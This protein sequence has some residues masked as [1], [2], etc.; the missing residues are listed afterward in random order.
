[1]YLLLMSQNVGNERKTPYGDALAGGLES[2]PVVRLLKRLQSSIAG[3][4]FLDVDQQLNTLAKAASVTV[5]I[6]EEQT[7]PSK[8]GAPSLATM[9]TE[10]TS[11]GTNDES[12]IHQ[13][14]GEGMMLG[15]EE[16]ETNLALTFD[17]AKFSLRSREIM[18]AAAK[19]KTSKAKSRRK[20][21][22][23]IADYADFAFET[24]VPDRQSF[25]S[26]LNS[27]EQRSSG[28]HAKK[29]KIEDIDDPDFGSEQGYEAFDGGDDG[30]MT[31]D[32]EPKPPPQGKKLHGSG[33]ELESSS[34]YSAIESLGRQKKAAKSGAYMVAP[35]YPGLEHE[36]TG[37]FLHRL[38]VVLRGRSNH[39]SRVG[40]R[41]IS[42]V[43]LKNRGLVAHKARINR[44]P[45]VKKRMQYRK[46][47]IRRKGA[48][49]GIRVDEGHKYGGEGTGIKSRISRSR[50]L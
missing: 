7:K 41:A 32:R 17:D 1:M 22:D 36:V 44:N 20:L 49:R 12:N 14:Q 39:V 35:K 27:I 45:R 6:V 48:V 15:S 29:P 2:H 4:S 28:K 31:N 37:K 21:T 10:S 19:S 38:T 26:T 47:L 8:T 40:E 25:A 24:K 9:K 42:R 5:P 3:L 16:E 33:S 18:T 46:A 11:K 43:I 34:F 50:K 23:G 13:L 30:S